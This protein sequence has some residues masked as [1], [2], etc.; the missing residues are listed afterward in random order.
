MPRLRAKHLPHRIDY[1]TP[2]AAAAVGTIPGDLAVDRPAYVE[3]KQRLVTDQRPN[4]ET[5]GQEITATTF[6]VVL[7]EDDMLPGAEVTV[8]KGSIRK[9]T[10]QVV[11][12]AKFDY[13]KRT[14]NHIELW[15]T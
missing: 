6:V 12:S 13:N 9:R 10:S 8:H 4:S 14:P 1:R 7:P 11:A 15:L 5:F 3:D 2:P